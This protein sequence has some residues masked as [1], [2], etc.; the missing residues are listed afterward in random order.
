MFFIK[1]FFFFFQAEDGIRDHCV[2]GVQTCALPICFLR[3]PS[4]SAGG[5]CSTVSAGKNATCSSRTGPGKIRL[6]IARMHSTTS[7]TI[8]IGRSPKRPS[9]TCARKPLAAWLRKHHRL[10]NGPPCPANP[11]FVPKTGPSTLDGRGEPAGGCSASNRSRF[12]GG[13]VPS[14]LGQIC[15]RP[16]SQD[17]R[18]RRPHERE[19]LHR[20]LRRDWQH[21]RGA[22]CTTGRSRS[23]RLRSEEHTSELQSHSDLVCRLL[24]EKKKKQYTKLIY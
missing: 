14:F 19:G 4:P 20:R 5:A 24:L 12:P 2:T 13:T 15:L 9:G 18:H 16:S 1:L 8:A 6:G 17:L 22:S 23:L 11:S 10:R 21:L 3:R 7:S